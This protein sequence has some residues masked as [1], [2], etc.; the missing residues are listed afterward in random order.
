MKIIKFGLCISLSIDELHDIINRNSIN[1]E[2]ILFFIF[3]I[4]YLK[5]VF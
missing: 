5:L 4:Y 3:F 1:I 2:V